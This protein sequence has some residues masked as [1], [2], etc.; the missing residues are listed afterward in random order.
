[1]KDT[2]QNGKPAG[3]GFRPSRFGSISDTRPVPTTW[4]ELV[5]T[6]RGGTLKCIT[7]Q[8]RSPSLD[9]EGRR[10]LKKRLPA[11]LPSAEVEGGRSA[12]CVRRLSGF[13]MVDIDHVEPGLMGEVCAKVAADEHTFLAYTTV[14]GRGVRVVAR[15]FRQPMPGNFA[16]VWKAVN[17]HYASL[18]G[19]E[20]DGQCKNATRIS[21]LCHDPQAVY[22]PD[23]KP[24]DYG[25]VKRLLSPG[26]RLRGSV[27]GRRWLTRPSLP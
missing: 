6:I 25:Y 26:R 12:R 17:A 27:A 1:M 3:D 18:T 11:F 23:A 10:A 14:T 7:E 4:D 20:T 5:A 16:A 9:D 22:R 24:F 15:Y 8:Y 13:F 2:Q 19:M 21:C